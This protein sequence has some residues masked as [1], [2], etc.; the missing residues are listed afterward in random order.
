MNNYENNTKLKVL[1]KMLKPFLYIKFVIKKVVGILIF[2]K[3]TL[4]YFN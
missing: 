2:Y 3:K 1:V 4:L